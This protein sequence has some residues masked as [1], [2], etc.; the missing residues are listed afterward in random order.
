MGHTTEVLRLLQKEKMIERVKKLHPG[1]VVH[2]LL[3][4]NICPASKVVCEEACVDCLIYCQ[5]YCQ[6]K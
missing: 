4:H 6:L 2:E 5:I 1:V 3:E